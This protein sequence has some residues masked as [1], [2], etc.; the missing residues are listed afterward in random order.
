MTTQSTDLR[1]PVVI[2]DLP[3]LQWVECVTC[4]AGES[5]EG[6]DDAQAWAQKHVDDRPTH[7]RFRLVNQSAWQLEPSN[8]G[9][10]QPVVVETLQPGDALQV[11]E[12][13][14][15][16][17][18][19]WREQPWPAVADAAK[20]IGLLVFDQ[21][22]ACELWEPLPAYEQ[23]AVHWLMAEGHIV[24]CITEDRVDVEREGH[25]I[26]DLHDGAVYFTGLCRRGHLVSTHG[27]GRDAK[28]AAEFATRFGALP[29][30]WRGEV[31]R[32]L[33]AGQDATE[34]IAY[35]AMF[36]N[37]LRS[38]YGVNVLRP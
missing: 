25:R 37:I 23:S 27:Q 11:L 38:T 8:A 13:T 20:G 26:R 6:A 14:A 18:A 28:I 29:A 16:V 32:R 10:G 5:V 21:L 24:G 17:L 7:G 2:D 31:M 35:A 36:I 15:D 34:V 1:A 12:R 22:E 9:G 19:H 33:I 3:K 4:I 30:G